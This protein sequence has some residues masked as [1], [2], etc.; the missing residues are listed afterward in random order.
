MASGASALRESS[1]ERKPIP[2]DRLYT[3]LRAA[4]KRFQK[5]LGALSDKEWEA[6]RAQVAR[7]Y[8]ISAR[9]LASEEAGG[10]VIP[11]SMLEKSVADIRDNYPDEQSFHDE[12]RLNGMDEAALRGGLLRELKVE[13]VLDRVSARAADI[14]DVD[15]RLY[16][17]LHMDRFR[18]PETRTSRHI[19]VTIND[20]YTENSREAARRR[21]EEVKQRVRKKP[22]LFGEQALKHSECPTSL[23]RGLLG[24]IPR[25]Q[26]Y[27]ELDE[28]LFAL[29]EGEIS[30]VVESEI[31]FHILYC[32]EIHKEGPAAFK[33]ARS[34]IRK[35]LIQRRRE[36]CK[37]NW[38][39][40]LIPVQQS[41]GDT[42]DE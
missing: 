11:D 5:S 41:I 7:E 23:N 9:V 20:E 4:L 37:R 18:Q 33:E 31:G 25:G 1:R 10:V 27:P 38:L 24:K 14:S 16:Y 40:K 35:H 2:A 22:K 17:Y 30:D 29:A 34:R 3:A 8:D 19:L 42:S 6:V 26:L 28:V 21:I 36:I 13:A 15:M 39:S 32:E 12:L